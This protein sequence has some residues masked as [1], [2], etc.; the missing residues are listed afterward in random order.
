MNLE[1]RPTAPNH[2]AVYD[3]E[4]RITV[5]LPEDDARRIVACVNACE[6]IPTAE[7]KDAGP[8]FWGR[9]AAR[10]G[11]Q[12]DEAKAENERLR[13]LLS[14]AVN[15]DRDGYSLPNHWFTDVRAAL[16]QPAPEA[17]E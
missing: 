12:R 5:S 14:A 7:L 2:Y 9:F 10:N 4:N 1:I 17:A 11:R 8:G 13:K 15:A 16:N 3:G 6:G